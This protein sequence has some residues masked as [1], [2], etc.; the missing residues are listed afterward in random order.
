T[1]ERLTEDWSKHWTG[2]IQPMWGM[3]R[4]DGKAYRFL[5]PQADDRSA[6]APVGIR[7]SVPEMS[8]QRVEVL[9]TRTIYQFEAGGLRLRVTFTTP[10]LPDDLDVLAR[11]VT[12]LTW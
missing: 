9:P 11:P 6:R 7:E 5:G 10:L 1:N 2:T 4:I 8:Q 3:A 12:Y